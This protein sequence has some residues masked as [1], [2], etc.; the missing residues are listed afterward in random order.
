MTYLKE[1]DVNQCIENVL[2]H[3]GVKGMKWG[4]KKLSIKPGG[5]NGASLLNGG[6]IVV[7]RPKDY[8]NAYTGL[9]TAKVVDTE[10][11]QKMRNLKKG[12][13]IKVHNQKIERTDKENSLSNKVSTAVSNATT[14]AK[15][16]TSSAVEA[17]KSLVDKLLGKK[18]Q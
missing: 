11:R 3:Y 17:G 10:N 7:N 4:E 6:R 2:A 1:D 5:A 14:K 16:V 18:K 8:Y 13:A 9:S 15:D 12:S